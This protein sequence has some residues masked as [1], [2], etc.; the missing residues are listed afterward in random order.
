MPQH[1]RVGIVARVDIDATDQLDELAG[2]RAV[3]AAGFVEM[4]A[5]KMEWHFLTFAFLRHA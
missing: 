1:S 2:L 4:F 5:D 3:M